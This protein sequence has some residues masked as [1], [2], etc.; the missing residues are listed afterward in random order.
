VSNEQ[1][2]ALG[3]PQRTVLFSTPECALEAERRADG[4]TVSMSGEV[5]LANADAVC[6]ALTSLIA[7]RP[8]RLDVDLAALDFIDSFGISRLILAQQAAVAAGVTMSLRRARTATRRV[9]VVSGLIAYLNV[10]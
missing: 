10:D 4:V 9:F 8:S 3:H 1:S 2:S 5:D 7:Q 6:A